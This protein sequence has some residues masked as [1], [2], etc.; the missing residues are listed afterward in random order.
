MLSAVIAMLSNE[1]AIHLFGCMNNFTPCVY[2]HGKGPFTLVGDRPLHV[3]III[4]LIWRTLIRSYQCSG[5][6]TVF[7]DVKAM[8][9]VLTEHR[10]YLR[11]VLID[12]EKKKVPSW[13]SSFNT[14]NPG[15][16]MRLL[17]LA[18]LAYNTND[19]SERLQK[20]IQQQMSSPVIS[21]KRRESVQFPELLILPFNIIWGINKV[22]AEYMMNQRSAIYKLEHMLKMPIELDI[23]DV[24]FIMVQE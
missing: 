7:T 11:D 20:C 13:R 24:M 2:S 16:I 4:S 15:R 10:R 22:E 3:L 6:T 18:G 17:R 9:K 23:C 1:H 19:V 5:G 8:N 21:V 14:P 12:V